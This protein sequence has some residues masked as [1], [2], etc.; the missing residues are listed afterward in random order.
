M[1][2]TRDEG[3]TGIEAQTRL[4][5]FA[6]RAIS[7]SIVSAVEPI[8]RLQGFMLVGSYGDRLRAQYAIW[9]MG[10]QALAGEQLQVVFA[11]L[12]HALAPA[13]FRVVETNTG[14][15]VIDDDLDVPS[16]EGCR[17]EVSTNFQ[18]ELSK[19]LVCAE[20]V[21]PWGPDRGIGGSEAVSLLNRSD[22]ASEDESLGVGAWYRNSEDGSLRYRILLPVTEQWTPCIDLFVSSLVI[23]WMDLESVGFAACPEFGLTD[24]LQALFSSLRSGDKSELR[25]EQFQGKRLS[26]DD[27]YRDMAARE[28]VAQMAG[29]SVTTVNR[30]IGPQPRRPREGRKYRRSK[31]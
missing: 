6:D 2:Y 20:L 22:E 12:R 7:E 24:R 25:T 26:M 17:V 11:A 4:P 19:S 8:I 16:L 30:Y 13:G 5:I 28:L 14:C 27:Y 23:R 15:V 3:G 29:I 21:V 10:P 31:K 18:H 1:R 9:A